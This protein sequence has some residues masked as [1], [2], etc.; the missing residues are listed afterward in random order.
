[1]KKVYIIDSLERDGAKKF[2]LVAIDG[3][4]NQLIFLKS[5]IKENRIINSFFEKYGPFDFIC[6][7]S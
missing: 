2:G 4:K 1:M 6:H 3:Q 7:V 5:D